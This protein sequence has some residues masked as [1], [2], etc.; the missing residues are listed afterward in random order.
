MDPNAI[1]P[2]IT[3]ITDHVLGGEDYSLETLPIFRATLR[4]AAESLDGE[5][6]MRVASLPLGDA[7]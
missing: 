2:Q 4:E 7:P 1:G 5:F 6:L 3:T